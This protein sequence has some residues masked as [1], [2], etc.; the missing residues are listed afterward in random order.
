MKDGEA[1]TS[2]TANRLPWKAAQTRVAHHEDDFGAR[3][4]GDVGGG[5]RG[6]CAGGRRD[7]ARAGRSGAGQGPGA[8][9]RQTFALHRGVCSLYS[10]TYMLVL[11]ALR[12]FTAIH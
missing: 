4:P 3:D 11:S 2:S 5:L 10:C 12:S 1:R 6:R 9:V 8:V 7:A